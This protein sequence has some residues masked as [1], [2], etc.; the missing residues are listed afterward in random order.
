[1]SRIDAA[2]GSWHTINKSLPHMTEDECK[3]AL[4]KE[5]QGKRRRAIVIRIHQKYCIMR[6]ERERK[7]LLSAIDDTPVPSFLG[8]AA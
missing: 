1:M 3:Q 4:N 6:L 2:L 7:E 8:G 5:M